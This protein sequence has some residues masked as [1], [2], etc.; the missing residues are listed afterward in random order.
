MSDSKSKYSSGVATQKALA[1]LDAE[2]AAKLGRAADRAAKYHAN[3]QPVNLNDFVE[4]F[5]PGSNAVIEGSKITFRAKNSNIQVVCD[6]R[7]GYCR[8]K[9]LTIKSGKRQYLDINGQNANNK[10][11]SSG[12]QTGRSQSEYNEITHFRILKREEM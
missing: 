8:L 5:A 4:K 1:Q 12:K 11:T 9:D 7:G 2:L 6:I 10:T 3:W